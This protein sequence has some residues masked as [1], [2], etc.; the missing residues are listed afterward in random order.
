MSR[1]KWIAGIEATSIAVCFSALIQR[2]PEMEFSA[3]EALGGYLMA[4]AVSGAT[5]WFADTM[6][7]ES[8]PVI[9]KLLIHPF[10]HHH[11]DPQALTHHGLLELCGNSALGSL[12]LFLL[13]LPATLLAAMTLAL[14]MTNIF[15]SWAHQQRPPAM[16]RFLQ[17]CHLILGPEHHA[18]HHAEGRGAYCVTSGWF[19]PVLDRLTSLLPERGVKT[20]IAA[21]RDSVLSH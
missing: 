10:R 5:H 17:R 21:S 2:L 18:R 20:P 9:G 1:P 7:Q 16:A 12:V 19:N 4:D 8:T 11:R 15:H 6:F 13:P 14:I 3:W